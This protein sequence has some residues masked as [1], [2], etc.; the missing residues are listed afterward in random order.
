MLDAYSEYR[1]TH[2]ENGKH[3]EKE[4]TKMLDINRKNASYVEVIYN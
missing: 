1:S 2:V 4:L 3:L